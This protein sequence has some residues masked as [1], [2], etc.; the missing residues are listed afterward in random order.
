[1]K[2]LYLPNAYEKTIINDFQN[3]V[4]MSTF[5]ANGNIL[6]KIFHRFLIF[7]TDGAFIS[8]VTFE[9]LA[10]ADKVEPEV[11]T[12]TK[13]KKSKDE[14]VNELETLADII[15]ASKIQRE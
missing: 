1:M 7:S 15:E 8:K 6:L 14:R 9:E 5:L 3:G 12:V 2:I 11:K 10:G 13:G 4:D